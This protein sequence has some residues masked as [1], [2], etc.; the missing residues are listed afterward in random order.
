M[1]AWSVIATILGSAG[2]FSLVQFLITRHD[3]QKNGLKGVIKELNIIKDRQDD[4]ALRVSRIELTTLIRDDPDN[5][6]AIIQVA[7]E[8]FIVLAG[9]AYAHTMFEKW[10]IEHNVPYGWLPTLKKGEENGRQEE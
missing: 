7:E 5:I 4:Q 8:Y 6:D 10:A 3:Q 9:N 2:L 1:E